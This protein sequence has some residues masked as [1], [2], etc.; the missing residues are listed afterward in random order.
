[1]KAMGIYL[2][3][4]M[5]QNLKHQLEVLK[6]LNRKKVLMWWEATQSVLEDNHEGMIYN[7]I[8]KTWSWL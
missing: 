1:M 3:D 5:K 6:E 2:S 7:P 8:T 4:D